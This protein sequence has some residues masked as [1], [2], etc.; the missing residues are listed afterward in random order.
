VPIE[1]FETA[2]M[3]LVGDSAAAQSSTPAP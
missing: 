3:A 2:V 1:Q